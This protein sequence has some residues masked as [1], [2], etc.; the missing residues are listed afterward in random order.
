MDLLVSAG[1]AIGLEL[2]I[3]PGV[4]FG[5]WFALAPVLVETHHLHA[6]SALER[7][8]D[9]V[10][11]HFV[12]VMC[13]LMLVLFGTVAVSEALHWISAAVTPGPGAVEYAAAAL[14]AGA[15]VKPFAAVVTVELALELDAAG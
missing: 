13:V 7:S 12:S 11:G 14:V 15:F 10:R 3:V 9:L 2:L 1:T 6:R 8:R 4:V 5:T